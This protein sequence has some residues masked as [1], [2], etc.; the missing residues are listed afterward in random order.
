MKCLKIESMNISCCYVKFPIN[1]NQME[2]IEKK[3]FALSVFAKQTIFVKQFL[4]FFLSTIVSAFDHAILYKKT[5]N[6][7]YVHYKV[8]TYIQ[9]FVSNVT[10][11]CRQLNLLEFLI[12][13]F[14]KFDISMAK[15]NGNVISGE[16]TKYTQNK[17]KRRKKKK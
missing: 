6:Y 10:N 3:K 15:T 4:V 8:H 13:F 11:I 16:W 2:N 17:T 7:Y 9:F 12:F 14:I 5:N 1:E